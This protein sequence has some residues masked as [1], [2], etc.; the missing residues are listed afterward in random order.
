MEFFRSIEVT[1]PAAQLASTLR[2]NNLPNWSNLIFPIGEMAEDQ[3]Y[4]GGIWGEF[5]L[6]RERINGG[7]RFSLRECP[8]ALCW[9]ITTRSNE[10]ILIHLTV[11]REDF[12][13][14]FH[15]EA[16]EFLDDLVKMVM[17]TLESSDFSAIDSSE[18]F[19]DAP[20]CHF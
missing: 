20:A 16:N 13:S 15:E 5:T 6:K 3:V 19:L 11:T 18:T 1:I 7:L 17:E 4:T 10:K 8:N 2:I 9:T 12:D 14:E